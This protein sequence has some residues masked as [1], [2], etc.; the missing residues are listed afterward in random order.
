MD[1][2]KHSYIGIRVGRVDF[3]LFVSFPLCWVPNMYAVSGGIWALSVFPISRN[4]FYYVLN[5]LFHI[6]CDFIYVCLLKGHISLCTNI[7]EC[8]QIRY[9]RFHDS[10]NSTQNYDLGLTSDCVR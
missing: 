9:H 3:M 8:N 7:D 6:F 5:T 4:L 1:S 10:I 2:C